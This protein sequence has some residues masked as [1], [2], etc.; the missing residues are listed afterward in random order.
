[1][2][3]H[4]GQLRLAGMALLGGIGFTMSLFITLRAL[5]GY[6]LLQMDARNGVFGEASGGAV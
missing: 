3:A 1:M 4:A 2:P 5:P 6:P